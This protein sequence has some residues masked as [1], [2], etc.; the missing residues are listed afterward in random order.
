[1]TAP[2][3]DETRQPAAFRRLVHF[4]ILRADSAYQGIQPHIHHFAMKLSDTGNNQQLA[5][6]TNH[7]AR[8][9]T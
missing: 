9:Y 1:M 8:T 7:W 4:L 2:S 5:A 3:I 6:E